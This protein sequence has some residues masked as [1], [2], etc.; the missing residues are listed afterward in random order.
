[1]SYVN[2][3]QYNLPFTQ[4]QDTKMINLGLTHW[5]GGNRTGPEDTFEFDSFVPVTPGFTPQ[6]NPTII[7]H[8]GLWVNDGCEVQLKGFEY[9]NNQWQVNTQTIQIG[10]GNKLELQN[11]RLFSVGITANSEDQDEVYWGNNAKIDMSI[12]DFN[13]AEQIENGEIIDTLPSYWTGALV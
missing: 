3:T 2:F 1:M 4:A 10:A 12:T 7:Y 13:T 8:L 11:V 5:G 9:R 6:D